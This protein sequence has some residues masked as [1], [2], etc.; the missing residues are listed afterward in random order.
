V[1]DFAPIQDAVDNAMAEGTFSILEVVQGRGYPEDTVDIFM[2]EQAAYDR[3]KFLDE[4]ADAKG[5]GAWRSMPDR[6]SLTGR[7]NLK[8]QEAR[9]EAWKSALEGDEDAIAKAREI[10]KRIQSTKYVFS[11]RGVDSEMREQI[12]KDAKSRIPIEVEKRKNVFGVDE[13][14]EVPSPERDQLIE[15]LL[16]GAH[17]TK[18]TAPDGRVDTAPG[19]PTAVG[20]RKKLPDAQYMA[21]VQAISNL[22]VASVAFE[23]QV[24]EDFSPRS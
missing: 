12:E 17:I 15:D 2:D 7:P 9:A 24:D 11:L 18:I 14:V 13:D 16:V 3:R 22:Q 1:T 8:K 6:E 23:G 21:L 19:Y 5:H 4:L 20:L 10:E